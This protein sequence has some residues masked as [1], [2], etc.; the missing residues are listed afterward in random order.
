MADS[1]ILARRTP[2]GWQP[3]AGRRAGAATPG[4]QCCSNASKMHARACGAEGGGR[5]RTALDR[6][7]S[8]LEPC[9]TILGLSI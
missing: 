5:A 6:P 9:R 7:A 1:S 8:Q 3:H 4:T 2:V